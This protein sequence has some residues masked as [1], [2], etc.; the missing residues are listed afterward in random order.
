MNLEIGAQLGDYRLLSRIGKGSYGVVYEAEHAITKRVDAL[1]L[2]LYAGP[3]A[4]DDEQRFL[5]EIQV[6]A[7]LQH[8]NIAAVY[9]AFR[10]EWGPALVMELVRGQSLRALLERGR[11]PLAEGVAYVQ[12]ALRG[13]SCAER[14]GVVHRDIKPENILITPEGQV[15]LTDF[16]LAHVGNDARLTGSGENVGTPCYMSPEQ[17]IGT[18]PVDG[19]S[20]VYSAGVVLYEVVTGQPPFAGTN[21][22]AV[23]QAQ[24][25]TPPVP[26]ITINPAIGP[27]LNRIILT[28]L[29]KNPE[30][31]FQ[32]AAEFQHALDDA[33]SQPAPDE[34][35]APLWFP[36][37][38]PLWQWVL[39]GVA[40]CSMGCCLLVVLGR[41]ATRSRTVVPEVEAHSTAA[42]PEMTL[43]VPA[44]PVLPVP[45]VAAP[46]P[47]EEAVPT[48][49]VR[50]RK[51]TGAAA[52][53][54]GPAPVPALRFT[55]AEEPERLAPPAAI[56][57]KPG[58][59]SSPAAMAASDPAPSPAS[60]APA[61]VAADAPAAA[62][63]ADPPA[64]RRNPVVRAFDKIFHK[65]ASQD[66]QK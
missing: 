48:R 47:P 27:R 16:G 46:E 26:P 22:F 10:T 24:R 35:A 49:P 58:N 37:R 4:A 33:M 3:C 13:L 44:L 59:P 14:L 2:M 51:P 61:P 12:A 39:A 18:E 8:P 32:S 63:A 42:F 29:E 62:K 64:K 28:A 53:L 56:P 40:A 55:A 21:G 50:A 38:H 66:P 57:E 54:Q 19:R 65:H 52:R 45:L 6:Q 15:K 9:T 11:L 1:K 20:D 25:S 7:R 17:V 41:L 5:R 43:P 34:V 60:A 30:R 31:R 23:M 36:Q